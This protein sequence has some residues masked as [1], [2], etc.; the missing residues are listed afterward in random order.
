MV[1]SDFIFG[2]L[3]VTLILNPFTHASGLYLRD[4]RCFRI[5]YLLLTRNLI[6]RFYFG[7]KHV[8]EFTRCLV[9]Y[10]PLADVFINMAVRT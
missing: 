6:N 1:Q 4:T 10:N 2:L 3:T 8:L 7:E 9:H 5:C